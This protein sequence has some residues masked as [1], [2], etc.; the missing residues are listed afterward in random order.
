[1]QGTFITPIQPLDLNGKIPPLQP[2]R[3]LS[4]I[5]A[6]SSQVEGTDGISMFRSIFEEKIDAVRT[7]E[8]ELAKEQYLLATGQTE[9]PHSLGI[10]SWKAQLT[11]D[12]LVS[13][14]T[15]ALEAYNEIMRI[16]L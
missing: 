2:I 10:A 4:E 12:S 16:S 6:D 14:R 1:M 11:V 15:K 13:L 3:S 7:T 9:D 5:Q 8:D